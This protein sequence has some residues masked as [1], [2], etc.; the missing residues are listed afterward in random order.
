MDTLVYVVCFLDSCTKERT[1]KVT[2]KAL[3]SQC[4]PDGNEYV[5]LD[6]IVD[7]RKD[8]NVNSPQPR[9]GSVFTSWQK[10]Q[11][12]EC[13]L[14]V[15]IDIVPAF[16]WWAAWLIKTR[17]WIIS[18][19]HKYWIELPKNVDEAYAVNKAT[20]TIFLYDA[21]Q[22]EMRH[23]CVAFDILMDCVTPPSDHQYMRCHMIVDVKMV[24]L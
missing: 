15:G 19:T 2:A 21:I 23:V 24:L 9:L 22:L 13:A 5:L 12:A 20:C 8:P 14:A 7:Y 1:M 11:V 6:S 10:L 18:L 16:N 3:Y 4:D 17:D